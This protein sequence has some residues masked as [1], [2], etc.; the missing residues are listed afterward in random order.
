MTDDDLASSLLKAQL[1]AALQP[2]YQ[3]LTIG[4]FMTLLVDALQRQRLELLNA[5]APR[6][7]H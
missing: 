3:R 2:A 5:E 1:L 7:L 6:T 4:E